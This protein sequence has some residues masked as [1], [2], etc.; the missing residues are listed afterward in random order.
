MN[1]IS[2]AILVD[3]LTGENHLGDEHKKKKKEKKKKNIQTTVTV[4]KK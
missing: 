4:Q 1:I 3:K 2:K